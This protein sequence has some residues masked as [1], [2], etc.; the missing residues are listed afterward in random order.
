MMGPRAR[1]FPA[2]QRGAALFILLLLIVVG[3][4]IAL[5]SSL[6]SS[7]VELEVQRKTAAALA[8]AKQA[9]LGRVVLD[10]DPGSLP[11][12]DTHPVG[13]ANEGVADLLS[14]SDCPSYIGRL[15]WRT[16][17]LADLRDGAGERLWY[18]LDV[19][20]HDTGGAVVPT[21]AAGISMIGVSPATNLAAVVIAPGAPLSGQN[22]LPINTG[23]LAQYLESYIDPN[24][25]STMVPGLGFN[26]SLIT[27]SGS[28][29]HTASTK[30][31]ARELVLPFLPH[32]YPSDTSW[33]PVVG[34]WAPPTPAGRWFAWLAVTNYTQ[35][36]ADNAQVSFNGCGVTWTIRWDGLRTVVTGSGSC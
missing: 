25:I 11:C 24:T 22:R 2:I 10:N 5:V 16:L 15:P 8:E 1:S 28:E 33:F 7:Q 31:M 4:G 6:K 17:K 34:N 23:D 12:P 9:L 13:S 18:A 21:V 19:A 27:I 30:R 32:P 29:V 14:G 36:N 20:F 26:D 35:T 3:A